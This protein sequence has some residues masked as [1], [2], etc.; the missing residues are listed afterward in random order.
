MVAGEAEAFSAL[1]GGEADG[2]GVGV[3]GE[4]GGEGG[5]LVGLQLREEV[6]GCVV[7]ESGEER[8]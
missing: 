3:G 7:G 2:A 6:W 8:G 1:E 4:L 5:G